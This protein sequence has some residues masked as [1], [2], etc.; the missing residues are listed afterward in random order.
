[1]KRRA[2]RLDLRQQRVAKALAG[3]VRQSR[4]VVDRLL[5]IKLRALA[6]DLVK[7][8]DDVRLHVEQAKLEYREQ[9]AWSGTDD[10]HVGLDRFAH[11]SRRR[12]VLRP[13]PQYGMVTGECVAARPATLAA[14]ACAPRGPRARRSP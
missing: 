4:D 8:V 12:L 9:P 1:M 11:A 2:E 14:R 6:T 13:A 3:D 10:Q 7:D 5:R